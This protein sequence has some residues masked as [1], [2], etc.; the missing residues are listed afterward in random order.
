M[1]PII[2]RLKKA[3]HKEVAEAQDRVVE[4]LY[5]VFDD[6]VLHGGTSI[7]RCYGGNRF[8]EDVD[9]Y[10]ERDAKRLAS[11]FITFERKGFVVEKKKVGERSLYSTLRFNSTVVRFEALFK[12]V[13]GSLKEY[14]TVE[15]N[16]ITVYTLTPEELI[17]EKISAYLNRLK[18]RDLYDIFFLLRHVK[19]AFEVRKAL[20]QLIAK[21]KAPVDEN[22]LKVLL[23]EGLVPDSKKMLDY[24]KGK[25]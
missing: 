10:M 9:V 15:G 22:D 13:S 20:E 21:F 18:V 6:A 3:A 8:S 1:I 4:A 7:W 19:D 2:L 25:V 17:N 14:E 24:I 5:E 12:K 23:L 16:L 11:L